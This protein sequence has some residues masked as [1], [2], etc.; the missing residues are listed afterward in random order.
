MIHVKTINVNKKLYDI[1][2]EYPDVK[3]IMAN[4]GFTNVLNPVMLNTMGKVMTLKN[5][6]L[7]KNITIE[8]LQAEFTKYGY[9]LEDIK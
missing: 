4:L 8:T 3:E 2:A 9:H 6:A 5:G 7:T 1:I